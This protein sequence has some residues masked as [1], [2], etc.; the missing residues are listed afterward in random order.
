MAIT[1][2][3]VSGLTNP[4]DP[5][6]VGGEDWDADHVIAGAALVNICGITLTTAGA[7]LSQT[8]VDF[9]F[10]KQ[11]TGTYRALYDADTWGGGVPTVMATISTATG[12]PRYTR[13]ALGNNG[14]SDYIDVSTIDVAGDAVDLASGSLAVAVY[15]I[16]A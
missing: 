8:Y 9:S 10:S 6:L 13:V 1:H 14:T 7:I 3:K 11:A 4:T 12:A 16:V 15:A 2:A 5:N